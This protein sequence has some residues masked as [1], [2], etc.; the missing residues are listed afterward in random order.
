M[1]IEDNTLVHVLAKYSQDT[2]CSTIDTDLLAR[3]FFISSIQNPDVRKHVYEEVCGELWD[4]AV[5]RTKGNICTNIVDPAIWKELLLD[6]FSLDKNNSSSQNITSSVVDHTRYPGYYKFY[7]NKEINAYFSNNT[8]T[9]AH[10]LLGVAAPSNITK[11]LLD[12]TWGCCDRNLSHAKN[13]YSA[14]MAA[15][16]LKKFFSGNDNNKRQIIATDVQ[17]ML[18]KGAFNID[19]KTFISC[20]QNIACCSCGCGGSGSCN[21]NSDTIKK[22]SPCMIKKKKQHYCPPD[23]CK[24]KDTTTKLVYCKT[25]TWD[26][27]A[28]DR[29]SPIPFLSKFEKCIHIRIGAD[30]RTILKLYLIARYAGDDSKLQDFL[31]DE[32]IDPN[33]ALACG[34]KQYRNRNMTK[35]Q[36]PC[37]QWANAMCMFNYADKQKG[38]ALKSATPKLKTL[39]QILENSVAYDTLSQRPD[40]AALA[41]AMVTLMIVENPFPVWK[42]TGGKY[43]EQVSDSLN[44]YIEEQKNSGGID[45]DTLRAILDMLRC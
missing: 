19:L 6:N 17:S 5:T 1:A 43:N 32:D 37:D 26:Q 29:F 14:A 42:K 7:N 25:P 30:S 11:I 44:A 22:S 28:R 35:A 27:T 8:I 36:I 9:P 20:K 15:A 13:T 2:S 33:S 16:N 12:P 3:R 45:G 38:V 40:G 31:E 39:F 23:P 4:T 24:Q 34:L 18:T 41:I 21:C 10:F